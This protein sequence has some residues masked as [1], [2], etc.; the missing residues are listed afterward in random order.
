MDLVTSS[1]CLK[2]AADGCLNLWPT[3]RF[4]WGFFL[5]RRCKRAPCLR[6]QTG[7]VPEEARVPQISTPTPGLREQVQMSQGGLAT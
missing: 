7:S 4:W 2:A 5:G 3:H 1:L 6:P